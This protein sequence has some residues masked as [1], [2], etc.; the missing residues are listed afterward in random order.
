MA[1]KS[2]GI[3]EGSLSMCHGLEVG[4]GVLGGLMRGE[5]KVRTVQFKDGA[6]L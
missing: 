6:T 1:V 4:R 3:S 5:F 2:S